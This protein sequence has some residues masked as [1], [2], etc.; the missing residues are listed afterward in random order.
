[1]EEQLHQIDQLIKVCQQYKAALH[2]GKQSKKKPFKSSFKAVDDLLPKLKTAQMRLQDEL[3]DTV[4]E[5][6]RA[7]RAL[8]Y[9]LQELVPPFLEKKEKHYY[10]L[11]TYYVQCLNLLI[12]FFESPHRSDW[13]KTYVLSPW[14][15]ALSDEKEHLD[16]KSSIKLSLEKIKTLY[17][18]HTELDTEAFKELQKHV[19][20]ITLLMAED[21][22]LANNITKKDHEFLAEVKE[23]ISTYN[24]QDHIDDV[25]E[26]NNTPAEVLVFKQLAL[27]LKT[28]IQA[29]E[30]LLDLYPT[31]NSISDIDTFLKSAKK[32]FFK[33]KPPILKIIHQ[34]LLD[35][36]G[37][38]QQ[39]TLGE[40]VD[41]FVNALEPF[42]SASYLEEHYSAKE[43]KQ[44]KNI[45]PH[46]EDEEKIHLL[47]SSVLE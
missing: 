7:N 37:S 6:V 32:Q 23:F 29:A 13:P 26:K 40:L 41:F 30:H 47:F 15:K 16:A 17:K 9:R 31:S 8:Y 12:L 1:M 33:A 35:N 27:K 21:T 28:L 2:K 4:D 11:Q 43:I 3:D 44:H 19:K 14:V 18:K 39:F 42:S 22:K 24:P 25:P 45:S 46:H 38:R 10:Y 20:S 34:T 36:I 5:A